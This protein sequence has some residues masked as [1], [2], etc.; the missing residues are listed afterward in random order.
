MSTRFFMGQDQSS[1]WYLVPVERRDEWEA[2]S[3]MDDNDEASWET[4]SWVKQIDGPSSVTFT[5][6]KGAY[7]WNKDNK[8]DSPDDG[9]NGRVQD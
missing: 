5:A 8:Y 6:P 7:D 2:W 1:H 9:G 3:G 4:P